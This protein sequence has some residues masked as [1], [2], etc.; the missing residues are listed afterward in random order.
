MGQTGQVGRAGL[1][2]QAG[3]VGQEGQ[4][5]QVPP[6][7][8]LELSRTTG[9]TAA[10]TTAGEISVISIDFFVKLRQQWKETPLVSAEK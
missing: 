1:M 5:S 2:G 10:V 8:C 6:G 4:S 3:R 9:V 7:V